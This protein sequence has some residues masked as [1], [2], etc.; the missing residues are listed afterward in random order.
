MFN[1]LIANG[2]QPVLGDNEFT[3]QKQQQQQNNGNGHS[4]GFIR[5]AAANGSVIVNGGSNGLRSRKLQ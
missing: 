2:A 1:C 5:A 3:Y 4:N